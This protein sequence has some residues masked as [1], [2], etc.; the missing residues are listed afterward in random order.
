MGPI[1]PEL[2][3]VFGR[4]SVCAQA[5]TNFGVSRDPYSWELFVWSLTAEWSGSVRHPGRGPTARESLKLI[6]LGESSKLNPLIVGVGGG[7]GEPEEDAIAVRKS[8][9]IF[10][11]NAAPLSSFMMSS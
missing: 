5:V 4:V 7:R 10:F 1:S 6:A 11:C 8:S 3:H 9:Y 2:I